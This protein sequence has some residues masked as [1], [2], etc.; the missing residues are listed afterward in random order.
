MVQFNP[1]IRNE[2][3]LE[4]KKMWEE[5]IFLSNLRGNG[6]EKFD[7]AGATQLEE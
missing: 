4:N 3:A 1:L 6:A 5:L 7:Q 2:L